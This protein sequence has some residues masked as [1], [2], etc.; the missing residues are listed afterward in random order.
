MKFKGPTFEIKEYTFSETPQDSTTQFKTK[1]ELFDKY[2][3]D[4]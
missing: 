2:R 3:E 4:K 1:A